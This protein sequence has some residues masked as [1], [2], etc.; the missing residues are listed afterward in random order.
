ML[1]SWATIETHSTFLEMLRQSGQVL[2]IEMIQPTPPQIKYYEDYFF[3]NILLLA[4][5]VRD[6]KSPVGQKE[7]LEFLEA[8]HNLM[9]FADQDSRKAIRFLC[10][11]FGVDLEQV[12]SITL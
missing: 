2:T 4:P 11:E 1:D 3:D 9:I 6:L 5:G 12:V 10:N 7:L 8:N